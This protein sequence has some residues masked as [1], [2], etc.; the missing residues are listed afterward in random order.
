[1]LRLLAED[2][3]VVTKIRRIEIGDPNGENWGSFMT[4]PDP[5]PRRAAGLR[6]DTEQVAREGKKRSDSAIETLSS[7]IRLLGAGLTAEAEKKAYEALGN[8]ALLKSDFADVLN[9]MT[10]ARTLGD[11]GAR[12]DDR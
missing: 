10:E 9:N 6:S 7:L 5:W 2:V 12:D 8:V 4:P 3:E 1:M 11:G